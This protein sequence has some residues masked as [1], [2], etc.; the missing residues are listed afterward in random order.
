MQMI[1]SPVSLNAI[2]SKV[3]AKLQKFEH[4]VSLKKCSDWFS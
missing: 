4:G 3:K 1:F 2:F